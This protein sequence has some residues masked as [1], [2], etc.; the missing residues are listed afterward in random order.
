MLHLIEEYGKLVEITG[1]SN[2]SFE[3]AEAFLKANRKETRPL[4]LQFFDADLIA[5]HEHLY[6]AVLN[7]LQAFRSKTNISKTAAMETMLY[8]SGKR[9][10]QRA[11]DSIGIKPQTKNMAVVIL[12]E[13]PKEVE[14]LLRALSAYINCEPDDTVLRLT[15]KKQ[16]KIC[17]AFGISGKELKTEDNDDAEK[18][19]VDLVVEHIALLSTQL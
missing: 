15:E 6:F 9:Q 14:A 11:I 10:I 7:A 17:K 1:Y 13:D 12:D 8:A 19:L 2:I 4:D 16:Q 18:T 5:T 3:K